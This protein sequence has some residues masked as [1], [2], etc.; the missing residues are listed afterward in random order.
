LFPFQAEEQTM[1]SCFSLAWAMQLC[2]AIV[3]II[4]VWSIIQLLLPYAAQFLPGVVIE[5][6]R[7]VFWVVLAI[8]IIIFIFG[9][10]SC[11]VG[12]GGSLVPFHH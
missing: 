12:V 7:I 2:I 8:A 4:G 9:L 5:I 6:I 11:L 10:I 3:I 1:L